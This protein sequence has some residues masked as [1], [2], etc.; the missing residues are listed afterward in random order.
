MDSELILFS[1]GHLPQSTRKVFTPTC[2]KGG[3]AGEKEPEESLHV[4]R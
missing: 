4:V 1:Q 2:T 3:E